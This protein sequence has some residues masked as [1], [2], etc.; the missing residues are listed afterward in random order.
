LS[1]H[2]RLGLP[3]VFFLLAFPPIFYM[4]SSSPNSCYM[5][6]LSHPSLLDHTNY[7]WRRVQVTKLLTMQCFPIS[8]HFIS[9]RARYNKNTFKL[10]YQL[11]KRSSPRLVATENGDTLFG[12]VTWQLTPIHSTPRRFFSGAREKA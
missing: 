7:T 12:I 2:L 4:H 6:C 10:S 9:L 1:T 3:S 5:P 11:I 8:C